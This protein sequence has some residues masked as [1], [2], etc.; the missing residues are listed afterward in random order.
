[1][2][3]P[4]HEG[5]EAALSF[6]QFQD[7]HSTA[8]LR[9]TERPWMLILVHDLASG[10]LMGNR[11]SGERAGLLYDLLPD[12]HFLRDLPAPRGR[13]TLNWQ[14][15]YARAT[16]SVL[17]DP[18]ATYRNHDL[19]PLTLLLNTAHSLG[20][21]PVKLAARL[22]GQCESNCWVDGPNRQWLAQVV[23]DGLDTGLYRPGLGWEEARDLLSKRDDSPVVVSTNAAFPSPWGPWANTHAGPDADSDDILQA[24]EEL[25]TAQQWSYGLQALR[26]RTEDRLEIRPD[27]ATYRFGHT[28]SFLDLLAEDHAARMDCALGLE[29]HAAGAATATAS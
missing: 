8:K 18:I 29:Q 24:W 5:E 26:S 13:H 11:A 3:L 23:Q 21:D 25:P 22:H 19:D 20:S 14:A 2:T 15:Q 9:R 16:F 10:L 27:W 4:V 17:E 28:L 12:D 7:P 6:I 1:M